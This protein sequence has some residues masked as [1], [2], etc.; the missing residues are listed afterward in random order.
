MQNPYDPVDQSDV[1]IEGLDIGEV[2]GKIREQGYAVVENFLPKPAIAAMR[3]AF[4]TEVPITEMR[5]I[6]TATGCTWRA[7]NLLAKTRAADG[8]FLD[9]RL[10]AVVDGVIGKY[11]LYSYHIP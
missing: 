10:R 8:V 2:V 9:A 11:N 1:T 6:G 3:H 7:H 5:A 4:N